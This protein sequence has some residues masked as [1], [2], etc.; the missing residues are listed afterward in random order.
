TDAKNPSQSRM[1]GRYLLAD[2]AQSV[3]DVIAILADHGH[4][5]LAMAE[6]SYQAGI[7]SAGL[8]QIPMNLPADWPSALDK[9][10]SNL[11][12]LK[13]KEKERLITALVETILSDA[14]VATQELELL[15]AIG[16]ALH[17]PLPLLSQEK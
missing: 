16:S 17:V 12:L 15:R 11:D 2:Q 14:H 10:L 13:I 4:S 5:E 9:A 7:K 8:E 6:Q 3:R 1:G